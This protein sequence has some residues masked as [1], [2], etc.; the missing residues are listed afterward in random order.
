MWLKSDKILNCCDFHDMNT[1]SATTPNGAHSL[2][3]TTRALIFIR[4]AFKFAYGNFLMKFLFPEEF[5]FRYTEFWILIGQKAL[6]T[7]KIIFMLSFL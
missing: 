6:I 7:H 4:H 2:I 1:Y 3:F 5:I